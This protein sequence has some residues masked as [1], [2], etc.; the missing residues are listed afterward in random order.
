VNEDDSRRIQLSTA[1]VELVIQS[2][3]GE[4]MRRKPRRSKQ[5]VAFKVEPELAA[6]LDAMPLCET[7]SGA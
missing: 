5:I 2:L 3:Y 6:L 7:C 1:G 4:P